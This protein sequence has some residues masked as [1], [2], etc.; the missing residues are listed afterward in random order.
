M[1]TVRKIRK[2]A[3]KT[4]IVNIVLP[5]TAAAV[6]LVLTLP[7]LAQDS[8]GGSKQR[9]IYGDEA[10][11]VEYPETTPTITLSK[12]AKRAIF[13]SNKDNPWYCNSLGS[14]LE[15]ISG[16][17]NF[18]WKKWKAHDN[19]NGVYGI[20]QNLSKSFLDGEGKDSVDFWNSTGKYTF[21]I[22]PK[23]VVLNPTPGK[24][25]QRVIKHCYNNYELS[26][27]QREAIRWAR[28]M[29]DVWLPGNKG[30]K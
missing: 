17:V 1:K 24:A 2:K 28:Y 4:K 22:T 13:Y 6:M 14:G 18:A 10:M 20:F 16:V 19:R 21:K 11:Y 9:S 3:M 29:Q 25:A 15:D 8:G 7:A 5:M 30:Y 27:G 23:G 12:F 26:V